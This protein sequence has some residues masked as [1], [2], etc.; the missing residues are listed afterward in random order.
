MT[1]NLALM[2]DGEEAL[3]SKFGKICSFSVV[4]PRKMRFGRE[5][6]T[7]GAVLHVKFPPG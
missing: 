6:H 3:K 2:V 7:T 1:L 5:A 4:S